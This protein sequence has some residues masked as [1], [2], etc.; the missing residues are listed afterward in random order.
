MDGLNGAAAQIMMS[1]QWAAQEVVKKI[2]ADLQLRGYNIW[3][4]LECMKGSV[5]D[6]CAQSPT[7]FQ[8]TSS[9][10]WAVS[11]SPSKCD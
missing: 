5:M 7:H 9:L 3:W 8:Y 1:Y 10:S 2:V 6:A 11:D 4:D